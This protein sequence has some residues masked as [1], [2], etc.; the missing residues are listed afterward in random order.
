MALVSTSPVLTDQPY[1]ERGRLGKGAS[2]VLG[3]TGSGYYQEIVRGLKVG[4]SFGSNG[5]FVIQAMILGYVGAQ[6]YMQMDTR[7]FRVNITTTGQTS[8]TYIGDVVENRR[9][10]IWPLEL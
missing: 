5:P 1:N 2:Y 8:A 3:T 4:S 6:G 7:Y 9:S 10:T